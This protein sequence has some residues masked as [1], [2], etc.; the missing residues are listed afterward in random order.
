MRGDTRGHLSRVVAAAVGLLVLPSG[1]L[2]ADVRVGPGDVTVESGGA[3]AVIERSPFRMTFLRADGDVALQQVPND[4]PA[5]GAHA[6]TDKD[7]LGF[8]AVPEA[9]AYQP[10]AFE[11]GGE[12]MTQWNAIM[13]AGNTLLTGKAGIAHRAT[14]VRDVAVD[15]DAGVLTLATTDPARTIALRVEP[16]EG[17]RTFRVRAS[18]SNAAGVTGFGD[19]FVARPGEAYRGFGGRHNALD[20]RGE[21]FHN[22]VEQ[23]NFGAGPGE[24][25][26]SNVPGSGGRKW[27][28][29]NGKHGAYYVQNQFV[30]DRFGFFLNADEMTRWRMASGR[31]DAWQFATSSTTLDYT[32]AVGSPA[33]AIGAITETTGRQRLAPEWSMGTTVLRNVQIMG[34]AHPTCEDYLCKVRKDLADIEEHAPGIVKAYAYEGWAEI[35]DAEIRKINDH[36]L[37]RGITPISYVRAFIAEDGMQPKAMVAEALAKG[38]VAKTATGQNYPYFPASP[39]YVFDLTHEDAP[40]FWE[41]HIRHQL[42]LGFEGFMQDFGEQVLHDMR[43]ANGET[44]VTMHNRYPRMFHRLT[45]GI[46]DRYEAE[47]PGRDIF[48]YTRAGYSGRPGAAAYEDAN[49]PGDETTDW[50]EATGLPSLAPDMLNRSIGGA[51]AFT[52]DIGG[53]IDS[54]TD[55]LTRDLF[56]RW[57][58]WSALTPYYRVHNSCCDKGTRMP[59]DWADAD[60]AAGAPGAD[61]RRVEAHGRAPRAGRTA[62]APP[63]AGVPAHG[64]ADHPADV[65]AGARRRRGGQAGP[66]VDAR[67]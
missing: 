11:V 17:R 67:S 61:A 8:D 56:I 58:Q 46:L 2:A 30:S 40:E 19:S 21:S 49:F 7:V 47:H 50:N 59:W 20:Q 26:S 51:V 52:T 37:G 60:A 66:A 24:P 34:N 45:R 64:D 31:A 3:R 65:A 57:S 4:L 22:W 44:G 9:A 42:D 13:W 38:Y 53:Y 29:P 39:A 16:D 1:A 25:L 62:H 32:V 33:E 36:L 12:A 43:F 35:P 27:M 48:M 6:T 14:E 15:D 18:L 23:E 10:F 28:I 54:Y 63:V 41:R 5:P 55:D